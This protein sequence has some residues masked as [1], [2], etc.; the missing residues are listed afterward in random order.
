MHSLGVPRTVFDHVY[1]FCCSCS[2]FVRLLLTDVSLLLTGLDATDRSVEGLISLHDVRTA[3]KLSISVVNCLLNSFLSGALSVY[4]S[5]K[6]C[7]F[8]LS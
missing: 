6:L 2:C 8:Y 4:L 1:S 5:L 7:L 3:N